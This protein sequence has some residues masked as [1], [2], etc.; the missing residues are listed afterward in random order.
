MKTSKEY[1]NIALAALEGNWGT[2]AAMIFIYFVIGAVVPQV[3]SPFG[4][5]ASTTVSV[6]VSILSLPLEFAAIVAFLKLLR[7]GEIRALDVFAYFSN[8]KAWLLEFLKDLYVLFWILPII[9][10]LCFMM[11]PAMA[12]DSLIDSTVPETLVASVAIGC[13][14]LII[15]IAAWRNY[16]YCL[17]EF[18]MLDNPELGANAAID[19]SIKMMK[20]M[21]WKMFML[22]LSFIGWGILALLTLGIGFILL[23]PY[24]NSAHAAF[25]EDLKAEETLTEQPQP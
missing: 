2:A 25:Y 6:G 9:L 11:V 20:G 21:K 4:A 1:K 3:G 7:S 22:D 12:M 19:Q 17:S 23:L 10:F 5:T 14:I 8:G 13:S 16:H 15:I 18:I 24:V